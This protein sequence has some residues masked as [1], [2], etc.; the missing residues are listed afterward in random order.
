MNQSNDV[1]LP[2]PVKLVTT[3]TAKSAPLP[4]A[5]RAI[6]PVLLTVPVIESDVPL[7]TKLV[8]ARDPVSVPITG[9]IAADAALGGAALFGIVA[10]RPETEADA[11]PAAPGMQ[12]RE[13]IG[14]GIAVEFGV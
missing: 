2:R 14:E 1:T 12:V 10:M 5:L 6:V 3:T 11:H 9:S 8:P 7:A 4:D 13:E